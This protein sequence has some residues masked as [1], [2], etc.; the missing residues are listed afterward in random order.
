MRE[1]LALAARA[2][3]AGEVPVGAVVV[4]DGRIVGR[5][6]NQPISTTDPTAHAE[7]VALRD[8]AGL[9]AVHIP[10]R[11][12]MPML[13]DLMGGSVDMTMMPADGT[14]AKM[15][16]GGRMRAI[17]L[18]APARSARL[19]NAPTFAESKA[20][21]QFSAQGVWVG[22]LVPATTPEPIAAQLHKAI[23]ETLAAPDVPLSA[24]SGMSKPSG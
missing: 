13:Q 15:T 3:E 7:I 1:A 8:A 11:G 20:L 12:G 17:A 18:A 5:G 22:V 14:I 6:F 23:A 9:N 21:A 16:E 19:P 4:I 2:G 10:Y 24:M